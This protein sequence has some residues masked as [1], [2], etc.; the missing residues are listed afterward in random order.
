MNLSEPELINYEEYIVAT[1]TRKMK[2]V[3]KKHIQQ[4]ILTN[5]I[6]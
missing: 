4:N 6:V 5:H 3:N 2:F 1:A